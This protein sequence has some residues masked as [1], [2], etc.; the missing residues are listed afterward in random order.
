MQVDILRD[1]VEAEASMTSEDDEDASAEL[2]QSGY[3]SRNAKIIIG[4][5]TVL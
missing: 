2:A 3:G 5:C 1:Y 4:F